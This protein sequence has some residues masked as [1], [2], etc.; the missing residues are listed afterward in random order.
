M[1]KDTKPPKDKSIEKIMLGVI[2]MAVLYFG[3]RILPVLLGGK[4]NG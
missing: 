3:V 4:S 2:L 1:S